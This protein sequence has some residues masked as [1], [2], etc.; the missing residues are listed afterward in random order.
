MN[1]FNIFDNWAN[2]FYNKSNNKKSKTVEIDGE[3]ISEQVIEE[4]PLTD[5]EFQKLYSR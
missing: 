3:I 1:F 4:R 5:E 2:L